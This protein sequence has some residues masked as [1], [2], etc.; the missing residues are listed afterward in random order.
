MDLSFLPGGLGLNPNISSHKIN[1]DSLKQLDPPVWDHTGGHGISAASTHNV[2]KVFLRLT[3]KS[4]LFLGSFFLL[5]HP[6]NWKLWPTLIIMT[7][8]SIIRQCQPHRKLVDFY[9]MNKVYDQRSTFGC[10]QLGFP[11]KKGKP[12]SPEVVNSH[13]F[14]ICSS[15]VLV[16]RYFSY[17]A[18]KVTYF[19]CFEIR[20]CSICLLLLLCQPYLMR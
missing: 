8:K 10:L 4:S 17:I 9:L 5:F 18:F 1:V 2:G 7:M 3:N 20:Y 19:V 13:I 11:L 16:L 14:Y 6:W 15:P 12:P